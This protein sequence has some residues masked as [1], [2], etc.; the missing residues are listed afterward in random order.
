MRSSSACRRRRAIPMRHRAPS[1]STPRTTSTAA[2]SRS[3]AWSTAPS[4]RPRRCG[5]WRPAPS[6]RP[7]SRLPVAGDGVD[8]DAL[9]GRGRLPGHRP[10]GRQPATSATRS[11][12]GATA[13]RRPPGYKDVKPMVF[14]GPSRRTPTST[15]PPRRS[16]AAEAQRRGALLRAGDVAGA[17][18]RLS[19]RLPRATA[20]GDRASAW[21]ASSISTCS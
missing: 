4:R 14:A 15:R 12:P 6:S 3:C 11:R 13:P 18:L 16:G 19:L 20:H 10:Q 2:S 21:S 1:S 7:R 5:R 17:R 9:G 8:A